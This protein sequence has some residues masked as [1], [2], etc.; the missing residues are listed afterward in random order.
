M[1]FFNVIL[2]LFFHEIAFL[3]ASIQ[4]SRSAYGTPPNKAQ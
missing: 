4:V 3:K 1:I 2:Y